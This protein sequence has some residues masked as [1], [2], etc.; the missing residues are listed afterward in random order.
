MTYLPIIGIEVHIELKTKSKMFCGCEAKHFRIKPNTHTCPV[1]LGLPGALPVPNRKAIEWCCLIGLTL[2]CRVNNESKFDRKNYFYPDLPKGYQISQYDMPFCSNGFI[3]ITTE[4]KNKTIGVT[5]VHMEED[6]GKLIHIKDTTLVDFN[7]SGVP[8][9][10]IVS[11]PNINSSQEAVAYLKKIQQIVRSL[12]VSNCD[13]EKGSMRCEVNISLKAEK[14][15]GLPKYKVEIKNINSFKFVKKAIDYEIRRQTEILKKGE[16]PIQET[17]GYSEKTSRTFSQ[18]SKEEAY[19][20]RYFPEPDIPPVKIFNTEINQWK[21]GLPELPDDKKERFIKIYGL[22]ESEAG[23]LIADERKVKYFEQ[24]IKLN[25]K[26]DQY[27]EL[28]TMIVNKRVNIDKFSPTSLVDHIKK[29]R[30]SKIGDKN[31]LEKLVAE[32]LLKNKKAVSEYNAG[33]HEVL[34]FLLGQIMKKS[35]GRANIQMAKNILIEKLKQPA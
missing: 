30:V 31:I 9:V 4:E 21:K 32:V 13:M 25:L 5:R 11:E 16:L 28:A 18:R 15:K 8:L 1:C 19:D 22:K 24:L 7:R 12:D 29:Q 2:N 20:Y 34:G 6:T 33:K 26:P 3:E 10:E 35:N 17:R 14:D 23:I 27:R